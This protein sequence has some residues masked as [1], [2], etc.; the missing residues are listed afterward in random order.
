MC[1]CSALEDT[2]AE[3]KNQSTEQLT[4]MQRVVDV[5]Q[6]QVWMN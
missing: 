3:V 5:W 4:R 2:T 6:A 1:L